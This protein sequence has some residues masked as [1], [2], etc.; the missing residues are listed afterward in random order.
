MYNFNS[1]QFEALEERLLLSASPIDNQ[2]IAIS[3]P[4]IQQDTS[5]VQVQV[6]EV[7]VIDTSVDNY[8]DLIAS[9][10]KPNLEIHFIDS[11]SDGVLQLSNIL[12][13]YK[14]LDALHI[15]S[16][17]A[18]GQVNLGNS[19]LSAES[20]DFDKSL[21]QGWSQSFSDSADILIYGCNVADGVHGQAFVD[22]LAELTQT[23]VAASDDITGAKSFNGDAQFE[24]TQGL[25]EAEQLFS[26]EDYETAKVQLAFGSTHVVTS[27]ADSGEGSLRDLIAT[28]NA[29]DTIVFY[30]RYDGSIGELSFCRQ[31]HHY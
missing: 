28:A 9:L 26:Q 6:T 20:L 25:I 11:N 19:E 21:I 27:N 10:D 18:A 16:H 29:G 7:L 8:E 17:G 30:P 13:A 22:E 2:E 24:Y 23:D 15:V 31:R 14:N 12:S 3:A 4:A 1:P 5:Q